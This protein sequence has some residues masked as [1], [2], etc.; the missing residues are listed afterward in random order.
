MRTSKMFILGT[1]S[2]FAVASVCV[3]GDS[4]AASSALAFKDR[5]PHF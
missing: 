5:C 4:Q 2:S 1:I 3:A